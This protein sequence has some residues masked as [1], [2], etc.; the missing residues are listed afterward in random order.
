[1]KIKPAGPYVLIEVVPVE[2]V[3]SGGIVLPEELT[4]REHD[5]RDIGKIAALGPMAYKDL[6]GCQ[7]PE[8]WGV[9]IGDQVEFHRY[10]GKAPRLSETHEELKKYRLILDKQIIAVM[11][12]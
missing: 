7:T 4:K 9:S 3:S 11:E 12:E 2:K 1:M 6:D 5:G 10:D 8:E